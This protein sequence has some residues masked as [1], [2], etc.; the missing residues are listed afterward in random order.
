MR[1]AHVSLTDPA[2]D[3]MGIAELVSLSRDAGVLGF[4]E[5]A[6][7]GTGAVV[8]VA[9]ETPIDEDRL[10]DLECVDWWERIADSGDDHRYVIAFTAPELPEGLAERADELIGTCEPNVT[11]RGATL[12]L[13][14]SQETI[15]ATIDE[16][17]TAGISPELR[18]FGTYDGRD[19]PLAELTDRQREAVRT[20]YEM[21][22]YE[23]PRT[24]TSE[25]VAAEL[26]VDS[27]TV[28]ELLQRA[29]RNLL[30]RH[31]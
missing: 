13:V 1:E 10:S 2:F 26:E 14:G 24:V 6:C 11:D 15:A 27:S 12:S 20:A 5:L 30:G 23:V 16:Y 17:E 8:Q 28:A 22:Y 25:D 31:L 7:H 19:H 21:G 18:K 3:R 9:V 29:E 4:E